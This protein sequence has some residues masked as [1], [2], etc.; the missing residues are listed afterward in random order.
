MHVTI[1]PADLRQ[2]AD[3]RELAELKELRGRVREGHSAIDY[4]P[5]MAR[6]VGEVISR[7]A[8]RPRGCPH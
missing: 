2:S 3:A 6:R 5:A 1:Q 4:S 7:A 8:L